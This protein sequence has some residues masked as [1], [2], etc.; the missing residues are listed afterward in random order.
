MAKVMRGVHRRNREHGQAWGTSVS[1]PNTAGT[2]AYMGDDYD[3]GDNLYDEAW[4]P[5][6]SQAEAIAMQGYMTAQE[7]TG[8]SY[9]VT[10]KKD[11]DCG[12]PNCDCK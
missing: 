7:P 2:Q 6:E 8:P 11:C 1:A 5:V 12:T 3:Q 4:G 9:P 10:S